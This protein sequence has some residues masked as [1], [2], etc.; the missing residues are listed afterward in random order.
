[1]WKKTINIWNENKSYVNFYFSKNP[2]YA[3]HHVSRD[4]NKASSRLRPLDESSSAIRCWTLLNVLKSRSALG[5]NKICLECG[6]ISTAN[7]TPRCR[8]IL[9]MKPDT[10]TEG[11]RGASNVRPR[12]NFKSR[13]IFSIRLRRCWRRSTIPTWPQRY[14]IWTK[15]FLTNLPI[16]AASAGTFTQARPVCSS[17]HYR[18]TCGFQRRQAAYG[19]CTVVIPW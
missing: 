9:S 8:R 5:M 1:M 12:I 17:L 2:L 3:F 4:V 15:F 7:L 16:V 19:Q 14:Q 13:W 6:V 18:F 11:Q 10:S